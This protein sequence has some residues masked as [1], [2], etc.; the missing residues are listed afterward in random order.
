MEK[1]LREYGILDKV[2]ACTTDNA[3]NITAAIEVGTFYILRCANAVFADVVALVEQLTD[4][5]HVRCAA[6]S[7]NLVV[8]AFLKDKVCLHCL[9]A[10]C[11]SAIA[12]MSKF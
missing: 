7:L 10:M 5:V 2:V 3:S 12:M 11:L 6:H 1:V 4:W 8:Q 9:S